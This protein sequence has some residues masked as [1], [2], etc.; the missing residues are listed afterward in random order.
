M[1]RRCLQPEELKAEMFVIVF[2]GGGPGAAEES[3]QAALCHF[4]QT[5]IYYEVHLL[6]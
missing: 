6:L 4:T 5:L 2:T 3:S 1:G